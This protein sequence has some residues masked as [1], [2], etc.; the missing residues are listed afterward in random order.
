MIRF[1]GSIQPRAPTPRGK[2]RSHAQG[3]PG[4][5]GVRRRH[6]GFRSLIDEI[7]RDGA[8]KM[9]AAA[10]QAEVTAYVEQFADLV[11]EDGRRLV[12]RNGYHQPRTVV[13]SAVRWR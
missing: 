12:V 9:L 3:S 6:A 2:V 5:R 7:V 13:T 4:R 10:L 11:D 1:A 8:R